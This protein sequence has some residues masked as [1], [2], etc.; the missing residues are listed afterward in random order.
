MARRFP[1]RSPKPPQPQEDLK[2]ASRRLKRKPPPDTQQ[3]NSILEELESGI[4]KNWKL[5]PPNINTCIASEHWPE[6]ES[7]AKK[8]HIDIIHLLHEASMVDLEKNSTTLCSN[9]ELFRQNLA[10]E[11]SS[12]QRR[13]KSKQGTVPWMTTTD[14]KVTIKT[15]H[16]MAED[17]K[18]SQK[19]V[20][21]TGQQESGVRRGRSKA[22]TT[23]TTESGSSGVNG[24]SLV[25]KEEEKAKAAPRG[26]GR[27]KK[28]ASHV[29]IIVKSGMDRQATDL[30][31]RTVHRLRGRR[32][33]KTEKPSKD[34]FAAPPPVT[35]A[36]PPESSG[37]EEDQKKEPPEPVSGRHIYGDIIKPTTVNF[38]P[39]GEATAR[40]YTR[41]TRKR[42]RA[43]D[44]KP[45]TEVQVDSDP[46]DID[47]TGF[48]SELD[49][50]EMR[51][52]KPRLSR[53]QQDRVTE[54]PWSQDI[55]TTPETLLLTPATEGPLTGTPAAP[56]T[57]GPVALSSPL[58]L[59]EDATKEMDAGIELL[60][61]MLPSIPEH[62][63]VEEKKVLTDQMALIYRDIAA[64]KTTVWQISKRTNE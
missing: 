28:T 45:P 55:P 44:D 31:I 13:N 29:E 46:R 39:E 54:P 42:G 49:P 27:P 26:K 10:C 1:R 52:R 2:G 20:K 37:D 11:I 35:P 4:I 61:E 40:A 8:W 59:S 21:E 18:D 7:D 25:L 53:L 58:P 5:S 23:A 43:G 19:E 38:N 22:N 30:P 15:L 62:A 16:S 47:A 17:T 24:T 36:N 57:V 32:S 56:T 6:N 41:Q 14:L 63:T 64:Y 33:P 50:K 3:S 12:R 9:N 34:G 51:R 60:L 48:L